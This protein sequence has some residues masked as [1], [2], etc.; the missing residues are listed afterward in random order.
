MTGPFPDNLISI[1]R[2]SNKGI[3]RTRQNTE[4]K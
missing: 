3:E 2:Q 1:D 4:K